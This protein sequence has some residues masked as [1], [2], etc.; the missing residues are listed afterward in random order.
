MASSPKLL[1]PVANGQLFDN[2]GNPLASGQITVYQAGT[3]TLATI[4]ANAEG[5]AMA[6]PVSLNSAGRIAN[7]ALFLD[8]GQSYDIQISKGSTVYESYSSIIGL[9]SASTS[10]IGAVITDSY[11]GTG[12]KTAFSLSANPVT[13]DNLTVIVDGLVLKPVSDY[14]YTDTTLSF[15]IAPALDAQIIVKQNRAFASEVPA[16]A[17]RNKI[18]DKFT[19]VHDTF[20]YSLTKDPMSVYNLT[21]ALNGIVLTPDTD[22]SL[23]A[24]VLTLV[25]NP[26]SGAELV[27]QYNDTLPVASDSSDAITYSTT[28][29]YLTTVLDTINSKFINILDV[30]DPQWNIAGDGVTDDTVAFNAMISNIAVGTLVRMHGKTIKLSNHVYIVSKTNFEIDGMGGKLL[31]ANGTP[32]ASGYQMLLFQSCTDFTVRNLTVDANRANRTPAEVPAHSVELLM[33]KRFHFERV[34]SINAVVD[35]F[36]LATTTQ[37]NASTFCQFGVFLNCS[38]DNCYRQGMSIVN[39]YNIQIIGGEYSNTV[40][41]APQNGIDVEANPGTANPGNAEIVVYGV[42]FANNAGKGLSFYQPSG[43]T[44]RNFVV[45]ACNFDNNALGAFDTNCANTHIRNCT[46][47]NNN[48]TNASVPG[49]VA[50]HKWNASDDLTGSVVGCNFTT[51]TGTIPAI[52]LDQNS[53]DIVVQNN[54]ATGFAGRG[55]VA[56]G[57]RH[58]ISNNY[59]NLSGDIGINLNIGSD[60]VIEKNHITSSNGRA[61]YCLNG[62]RARIVNN[63]I[64]DLT[65]IASGAATIQLDEDDAI[66]DSNT[67]SYS[68]SQPTALAIRISNTFNAR[69][70]SNNTFVNMHTTDPILLV[71]NASALVRCNNFGGT[72]NQRGVIRSLVSKTEYYTVA[73][74]PSA[75]TFTGCRAM[76]TDATVTT[77]AST[78]VGGGSNIVPV[79]SDGTN[80]KIG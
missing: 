8:V 25:N 55:I 76:V 3:L 32:V 2:L 17:L 21:V 43:Y 30:T 68:T 26:A 54:S 72:A 48:V 29:Q 24:N 22:Y 31:M 75:A 64:W 4:F 34:R 58:I 78:V 16:S 38:T 74:L 19:L 60:C 52:W 37:T 12:S 42:R 79:W 14:A 69:S 46:F 28:G 80:W 11:T 66:I 20:S 9:P 15:T 56:Y 33:C 53:H 44:Q 70:I 77:F 39:G 36:Y 27:V 49:I 61:I 50:Y 18:V 23:L 41:T 73:I 6:N 7:G 65:S 71:G 47:L 10:L 63:V 13:I 45:D 35:G 57:A 51:G 67:I 59:I 1:S 62:S 40:G 5:S